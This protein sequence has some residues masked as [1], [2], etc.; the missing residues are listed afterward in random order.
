MA[1]AELRTLEMSLK[2]SVNA[3]HRSAPL[4]W[5]TNDETQTPRSFFRICV[6]KK[7]SNV[8]FF[9]NLIFY[10]QPMKKRGSLNPCFI[11][12]TFL[13][14]QKWL[15]SQRDLSNKKYR[16]NL[17]WNIC[18]RIGLT[19]SFWM[20]KGKIQKVLLY[21]FLLNWFSWNKGEIRNYIND[22]FYCT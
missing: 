5:P 10:H 17:G 1:L 9:K 13:W 19:N 6:R 15:Q 4:A 21:N 22:N 3:L 2:V 7:L 12:E 11:E 18:F 16:V 14:Q 20:T 8:E